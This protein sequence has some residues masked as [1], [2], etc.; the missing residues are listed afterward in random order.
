MSHW[1]ESFA[2]V[3]I[4]LFI[5]IDAVGNLPFV[6]SLSEGM[7]Q[8]EQRRMLNL[9]TT[10]AGLVG[11]AFLFLGELILR[12]MGISVGSFAIAGGVILLVLSIRHMITGHFVDAIK[13][14]I[15]AVVPIGTP[16]TVGPATITT[17][18]L[19]NTEF[20]TYMV[21][22][23]FALNIIAVW[24]SFM[25]A[26]KIAGFLGQGGMKALSKVFN[27]LLAAIAVSMIIRGLHLTGMVKP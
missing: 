8:R 12:A 26:G 23:A 17:L 24:V 6:M 10:T 16:L 27:L 2:L 7:S 14:E 15:V 20:P 3:F 18:M 5:A 4:P 19:L 21:L 13:E 9:A 25:A 1:L 22:I 11:I